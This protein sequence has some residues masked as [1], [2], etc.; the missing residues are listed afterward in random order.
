[1][2]VNGKTALRAA[3][4]AASLVIYIGCTSASDAVR[5]DR[6]P[7]PVRVTLTFDDS[8]KDHLLIA[9][10]LLEKRGWRGTFNLVTDKIGADDKFLTWDDVR[11]LLRRGHEIATHTKTHRNLVVLLE[12]EGE[13]AVRREL[14]E[15]RDAIADA[16]GFTPR[17]LCP[18]F[19]RQN[20]ET[21]RLCRAEGMRQMLS[22]RVN[23]GEG[24]EGITR[25]MI[26][27]RIAKGATRLDI[28]HHGIS[29]AEGRGGWRP[30]RDRASFERHLDEIAALEREGRVVV[31][32]YDGM[33]SDCAL[34]AAAWPRH[35]VLALSFDDRNM[36]AWERAF[37]IFEKY[38]ASVTFFICG[39]IGPDEVGFARQALSKGH[40]VGLHGLKH[41]NADDELEK[42]GAEGYWAAE[43]VPQLS[44]FRAAGVPIRSFA[45]PNCRRNASTDNV[46]AAHG[47]TKVRG[48]LDGVVN[49]NPHDPKGEKLDK[50]RPVATSGE[51][52]VPATRQMT[53]LLIGNVIMGENYHTDI[54]DIMRAV[55][56]AGERAETLS[57]VSH[58]IAPGAK[59]ISMKTEWLERMLSEAAGC[60]VVVRGV[61]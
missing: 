3:A 27:D 46:F 11:E 34:K 36:V 53:S 14:A 39:N 16:T 24:R 56:R 40:E 35:G 13:E 29:A 42:R 41:R 21:E 38:G 61:R 17:F 10:P 5:Q 18:P 2:N 23:F 48:R 12:K 50:W 25:K 44:A 37:P 45:Y 33:A 30:F 20:D 59:G 57:I 55:R 8:L 52:F 28:L 4:L 60:G 47:F 49:P 26:M 7:A 58:G 22:C 6:V 1:M 9:A 15:S 31:T 54:E 19:I 32:D 51:V 43:V